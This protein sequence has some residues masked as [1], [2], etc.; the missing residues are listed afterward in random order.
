M[1]REDG[2]PLPGEEGYQEGGR[3]G[4]R[5]GGNA[6]G[7]AEVMGYE[8]QSMW[9]GSK[10]GGGKSKKYRYGGTLAEAQRLRAAYDEGNSE[11]PNASTLNA[12]LAALAKATPADDAG[13]RALMEGGRRRR[14]RRAKRAKS[15][16]MGAGKKKTG[17]GKK[18]GATLKKLFSLF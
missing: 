17:G 1:P 10:Y 15:M 14:S 11:V 12:K 8:A 7:G 9:A 6:M 5:R 13:I 3:R 2:K 18:K 4:G 16:K